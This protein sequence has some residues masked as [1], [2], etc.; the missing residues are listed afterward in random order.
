MA[1]V[2]RLVNTVNNEVTFINNERNTAN[3]AGWRQ[4][5]ELRL[6]L[7]DVVNLEI[8]TSYSQNKVQYSQDGLDDRLTNR[9]EYGING[10]NYFFEDL[11][12]G[13]D[14]TKVVN[15]GFDNSFVNNP[16]ILRLFMEYK[17]L[18]RGMG[19]LRL[20]GFDLFDQNS[21]V[22]RDVFDNVIVDRRVNRLGRYF[23][24]SFIFR[25]NKFGG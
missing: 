3:I 25:V 2:L 11:T 8:E 12:L 20:D 9:F 13:Y 7:E 22:T 1:F 17:F 15:T 16:A 19:T 18:K 24:M 6:D 14:F 23:M 10:R 5:L 4:E 21:G